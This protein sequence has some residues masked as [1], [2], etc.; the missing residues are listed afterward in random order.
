M[1]RLSQLADHDEL[2][3]VL[4]YLDVTDM[5][6]MAQ[7]SKSCMEIANNDDCWQV[8][9]INICTSCTLD[10]WDFE[11]NFLYTLKG[12]PLNLPKYNGP[13]LRMPYLTPD[14]FKSSGGQW[15]P[16]TSGLQWHYTY[17]KIS[18]SK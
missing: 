13:P 18:W 3:H 6:I 15:P 9:T 2:L 14:D 8:H 16:V 10:R 7:V 5:D 4:S 11:E 17:A 1:D 12:D